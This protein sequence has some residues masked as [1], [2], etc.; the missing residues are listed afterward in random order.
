MPEPKVYRTDEQREAT[1]LLISTDSYIYGDDTKNILS[2]LNDYIST[3]EDSSYL[4]MGM[5]T[6]KS[7]FAVANTI[8]GGYLD[9]LDWQANLAPEK[10]IA[11]LSSEEG[12]QFLKF[13]SNAIL[14]IA[15]DEMKPGSTS[16]YILDSIKS[17]STYIY[18]RGNNFLE[19]RAA[20]YISNRQALGLPYDKESF[21]SFM[22][23]EQRPNG[24]EKY[25][26]RLLNSE[27][28]DFDDSNK[29]KHM[30]MFAGALSSAEAYDGYLSDDEGRSSAKAEIF[31]RTFNNYTNLN[32]IYSGGFK[33]F[34]IKEMPLERA[35]IIIN[36]IEKIQGS[37]TTK[38]NAEGN[39][40]D[41]GKEYEKYTS[42]TNLEVIN[43]I[44]DSGALVSLIA[45]I[46]PSTLTDTLPSLIKLV[47]SGSA[48]GGLPSGIAFSND[49]S[50]D[51]SDKDTKAFH[52][53]YMK[54][55]TSIL[56]RIA[57]IIPDILLALRN[58]LPENK[59]V[60]KELVTHITANRPDKMRF[61]YKDIIDLLKNNVKLRANLAKDGKPELLSELIL[62][63]VHAGLVT[64]NVQK[65][66]LDILSYKVDGKP[67]LQQLQ[68]F[69][70]DV[71]KVAL[72]EKGTDL[73]DNL[74]GLLT[75]LNVD[76]HE[77]SKVPVLKEM[78]LTVGQIGELLAVI[79]DPDVESVE[80]SP[81]QEVEAST[82]SQMLKTQI[83]SANVTPVYGEIGKAIPVDIGVDKDL[84]NKLKDYNLDEKMLV[85]VKPLLEAQKKFQKKIGTEMLNDLLNIFTNQ[86]LQANKKIGSEIKA[87]DKIFAAI[88]SGKISNIAS[89]VSPLD[90]DA[91]INILSKSEILPIT[92]FIKQNRV[93]LE[94]LIKD[95]MGLGKKG[96]TVSE[97][98]VFPLLC[99]LDSGL[100]TAARGVNPTR[101]TKYNTVI[102]ATLS[103]PFAATAGVGMAVVA[104]GT[105]VAYSTISFFKGLA[106]S[107]LSFFKYL[108]NKYIRRENTD[109]EK[110]L[111]VET[112]I[113]IPA[114]D[115]EVPTQ[116]S[117]SPTQAK[118]GPS[119]ATT[120]GN[121]NSKE[122][123]E[124]TGIKPR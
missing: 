11:A 93:Q 58:P 18:G 97:F 26:E 9:P 57:P 104:G 123:V 17:M 28:A 55:N 79:P 120:Q 88:S 116:A 122:T 47:K 112:G 68:P 96:A 19:A 27:L 95:S 53:N 46:E 34:G 75:K 35:Q 67:I 20:S 8:T 83:T 43:K 10:V 121:E 54:A 106:N 110:S 119:N 25:C 5:S 39:L 102:L 32:E 115:T 38:P 87:L 76:E 114:R 3:Y 51:L 118:I 62:G 7:V 73:K 29:E 80:L 64:N 85:K 69:L 4:G 60:I 12:K 52:E 78:G 77:E 103:V 45:G 31:M 89:L 66:K 111:H 124:N 21:K 6:V 16:T 108:I 37:A 42:K 65:N 50:W 24:V 15:L 63:I 109:S 81:V 105:G 2:L 101:F 92:K 91:P 74:S 59:R 113:P 33:S 70:T 56:D 41:W 99:L 61:L 44:I 1:N 22:L 72:T 30:L 100:A 13:N 14:K 94:A 82:T 86:D 90:R 48:N 49:A 84:G 107:A 40:K 98:V 36:D 23:R 71:L 117:I